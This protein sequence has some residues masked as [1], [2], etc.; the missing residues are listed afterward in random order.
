MG[1][2]K[3]LYVTLCTDTAGRKH[4]TKR[5]CCCSHKSQLRHQLRHCIHC[6]GDV[7]T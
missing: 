5:Y 2:P 1:K 6:L 3:T 7:V 4:S